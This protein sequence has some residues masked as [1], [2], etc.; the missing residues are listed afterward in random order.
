MQ[1]LFTLK[2]LVLGAH[3]SA[4]YFKFYFSRFAHLAQEIP[5]DQYI[6]IKRNHKMSSAVKNRRGSPTKAD[7]QK[8]QMEQSI[9][10]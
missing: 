2:V 7:I 10:L 6:K 4:V 1:F 8:A 3:E 9:P 5:L